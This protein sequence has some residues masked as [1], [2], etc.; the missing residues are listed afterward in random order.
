MTATSIEGRGG[1]LHRVSGHLQGFGVSHPREEQTPS[2][3]VEIRGTAL[4][5]PDPTSRTLHLVAPFT[6][7]AVLLGS[8]PE[9]SPHIGEEAEAAGLL[10]TESVTCSGPGAGHASRAE[11]GSHR[12]MV[13]TLTAETIEGATTV[14]MR[15]AYTAE[16]ERSTATERHLP[17][18]QGRLT[19][20]CGRP[21][22][23]PTLGL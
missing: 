21:A 12:K 7:G 23:L 5:P 3:D 14:K 1:A 18:A 10:T 19:R 22:G 4:Y 15:G 20:A 11:I 13:A 6:A 16:T 9:V 2:G 8:A 17:R